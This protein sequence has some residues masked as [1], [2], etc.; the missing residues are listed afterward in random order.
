LQKLIGE[1]SRITS[2]SRRKHSLR[3][4]VLSMSAGC[5]LAA[6]IGARATLTARS[7]RTISAKAKQI[8]GK[9]PVGDNIA[10]WNRAS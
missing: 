3:T 5:A 8:L 10:S 1:S 2:P 6:P 4:I 9:R 7:S